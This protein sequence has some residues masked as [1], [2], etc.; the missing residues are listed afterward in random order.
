[1]NKPIDERIEHCMA[2]L[3]ENPDTSLKVEALWILAD[4]FAEI[5]P[6]SPLREQIGKFLESVLG[7]DK[8]AVVKHEA[9]YV[10]GENNLRK[11]I[12]KLQRA[13]L[14][15]QS[16]LVRHEAIEALGLL[17]DFGSEPIIKKALNDPS[18]AV[19]ETAEVVLKQLERAKRNDL[20]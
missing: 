10:I 20:D 9:C 17:Q 11:Q 3:S 1:M 2:I 4:S 18:L 16:E 15:D 8:S 6:N 7:N 5:P 12:P 13:A 19:K 14:D